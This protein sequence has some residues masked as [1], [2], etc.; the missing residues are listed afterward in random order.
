MN[1]T[2][3]TGNQ[4]KADYLARYLG[5]PVE[6]KKLDLDELQS[7]D[8]NQIVE[9][10]VKQAY[11]KINAPV[12]VED[13][14]LEFAALGRLPGTFIKFFLEEMS[15]E[16]IC[17]LLDGKSREA[18]AKC[19]FG[20]YDGARLELFE[21]KLSGTIAEKPSGSKGFG[22][23]KIFIPEGYDVTR[24]NLDEQDDRKTYMQIKPFEQLKQFLET[25]EKR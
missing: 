2:F 3:I 25:I 7:L 18:T 1:I 23:D 11:D 6:H 22:W 8:L 13:V 15:F 17:S 9:H 16:T 20:Y 21:G 14:S 5:Y 12:L 24:A 10:K 19:V 4:D